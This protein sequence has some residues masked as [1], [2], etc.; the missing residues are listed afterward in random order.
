M[1]RTARRIAAL[2]LA[3]AAVPAAGAAAQEPQTADYQLR[4]V[5][6]GTTDGPAGA[7][8]RPADAAAGGYVVEVACAA[9]TPC[10][11]FLRLDEAVEQAN[12]TGRHIIY[13]VQFDERGN[14]VQGNFIGTDALAASEQEDVNALL[15]PAVQA[16][17]EAARRG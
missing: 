10:D 5:I 17:R 1:F 15:L 12:R 14:A 16:A 9:D 6:V 4:D 8:I 11:S 13:S 7:Q 2:A 3:V